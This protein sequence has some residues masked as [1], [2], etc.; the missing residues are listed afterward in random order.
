[1]KN[2]E[3]VARELG[4]RTAGEIKENVKKYFNQ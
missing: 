4:D 2:G 3:I 1:M